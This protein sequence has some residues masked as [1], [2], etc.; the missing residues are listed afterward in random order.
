[1]ATSLKEQHGS[2]GIY[3]N[4]VL[5]RGT[6]GN[7]C[8]AKC[9]QLV[10]AAK[11]LDETLF[12]FKPSEKDSLARFEEECQLFSTIKHPNIV[13]HIGT[14]THPKTK[15]P[16]L[17]MEML[18]ENLNSFLKQSTM[19]LPYH[20]QADICY[21]V[22]LALSH[23]HFNEII[24]CQLTSNN[25]LL[26]GGGQRAKVSDFGMHKLASISSSSNSLT[27][28]DGILAYMPP[29]ASA[30]PP[31]YTS[32]T[33]CFSYG[34][35][36]IEII[37][38]NLPKTGSENRQKDID[39]IPPDHPLLVL[40]LDCLKDNPKERLYSDTLCELLVALRGEDKYIQSKK[41]N[42]KDKLLLKLKE[43]D[44]Q[45]DECRLLLQNTINEHTKETEILTKKLEAS[46]S[47]LK[48]CSLKLEKKEIA[49]SEKG[50]ALC[51]EC[52][53]INTKSDDKDDKGLQ[54]SVSKEEIKETNK[55]VSRYVYIYHIYIGA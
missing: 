22:S 13:Q 10:C 32:K 47:M 36:T 48:E 8:K 45:L 9:G 33:D 50:Q 30:T 40:A 23:L 31:V 6:Y 4:R 52:E 35:L 38:Q 12:K 55:P 27:Q 15:Q 42:I 26:I 43:K 46:E 54:D 53:R 11:I 44:S 49:E 34:V 14:I 41:N 20:L 2:V 18:D 25:V 5:G 1:M 21:D 7:V 3:F 28:S 17:I 19:P 37:T 29:E 51:A 24:H 16:I 39:E